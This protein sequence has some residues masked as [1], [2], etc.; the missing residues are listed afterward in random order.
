MRCVVVIILAPVVVQTQVKELVASHSS[1]AQVSVNNL[2]DMLVDKLLDSAFRIAPL[3]H[4]DLHN[5]TLFQ[6]SSKQIHFTSPTRSLGTSSLSPFHVPHALPLTRDAQLL[7]PH[8]FI[9]TPPISH[10]QPRTT[11]RSPDPSLGQSKSFP[12]AVE[13]SAEAAV[14]RFDSDGHS[15]ASEFRETPL[16]WDALVTAVFEGDLDQLGPGRSKSQEH[17]YA[18]Y[19]EQLL[20]EW[21]SVG[22]CLKSTIF[23]FSSVVEDGKRKSVP[24]ADGDHQVVWRKNVFPYFLPPGIEHHCIWSH[25]QDLTAS[26]ILEVLHRDLPRDKFEYVWFVNPPHLKSVPDVDHAHV[27]ARQIKPNAKAP[28]IKEL[29]TSEGGLLRGIH[30]VDPTGTIHPRLSTMWSTEG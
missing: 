28:T 20:K 11:Q 5:I 12:R 4:A 27:I 16:E 19:R 7:T 24:R 23:G 21:S 14:A 17:R 30:I 8:S 15:A 3:D 29:V 18:S 10:A 26:H 2:L 1:D 22:E 6:S 9:R 25:P 13:A